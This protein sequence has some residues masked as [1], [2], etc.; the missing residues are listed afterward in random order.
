MDQHETVFREEAYEL[1][2]ELESSLLELENNP[3]DNELISKIFRA[4]HT[5]KGS[6]A[7]FGFDK[8][9]TFTH[10]IETVYDLLRNGKIT[11]NK[12]LITITL[13]SCD[14]IRRMIDGTDESDAG[15]AEKLTLAFKEFLLSAKDKPGNTEPLKAQEE[16]LTPLE[17]ANKKV[18]YRIR[19]KPHADIFSRGTNTTPLLTELRRMGVCKLMAQTDAVPEL[20]LLNPESCYIYWDIML[21]T[22]RGINAIK[23]V[24]IFVEDDCELSIEAVDEGSAAEES[25]YKRLGEILIERGDV[26]RDVVEKMMADHEKIGEKLVAEG[27]VAADKIQSALAEQQHIQEM[28]EKTKATDSGATIRVPA[29]RLDRLVNMVGE[30]VTVQS[31][32]SQLA[33]QVSDADLILVAEEVERLT[34]ELRDNTMS[35]R[36]MPIGN[37]FSNFKRLVRDLSEE[38]GKQINLVTEG[39]ET[40]LDKTVIEKLNDPLIHLIRNSIDHGIELP[41]AREQKGKPKSGTLRLT[42]EHAGAHVLIAIIDDGAGLDPEA[43]RRKAIERN[44]ISADDNLTEKEIFALIFAPGFSMAK[45]ITN[46]SGRGVGMDVVKKGIEGLS[47]TIV[48]ESKINVGT[49][50]TL[51]LP[52]TMAIIDGLLVRIAE[53]FFVLPLS[54]I[55]ECVELTREDVAQSHGRNIVHIRGEVVPYIP[56]RERFGINGGCPAI[57][58]VIVNRV[59]EE[60]F[61]LVVDQVIGQHQTVIKNLGN[62]YRQIKEVSGATILGDGTVALIIDITQL[63]AGAVADAP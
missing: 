3:A 12:E 21:T 8:V 7:M 36:M 46:V 43:I 38:L 10:D 28:R 13:S 22:N 37:T 52:L 57:E 54:S 4:M 62:F 29:K 41:A 32:L 11:A 2:T 53:S 25:D 61:G 31:R 58:Q 1:L 55:E 49:T 16:E 40:E 18:T 51:K 56:L 47:G 42:A 39:A 50:I 45:T 48:I 15:E 23:D 5:I 24:F 34:A 6:G 20:D 26:S 63:V 35:I 60:R 17:P 27:F 14:Q 30:L 19:F 33:A 59:G 9:A 44:I